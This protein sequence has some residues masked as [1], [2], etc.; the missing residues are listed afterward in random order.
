[1]VQIF[2][3]RV[4]FSVL[5][6]LTK[7]PKHLKRKLSETSKVRTLFSILTWKWNGVGSNLRSADLL[8]SISS[9]SEQAINLNLETM[10]SSGPALKHC[11]LLKCWQCSP[12]YE[13]VRYIQV[14]NGKETSY[15]H[16]RFSSSSSNPTAK[17]NAHKS[18]CSL[19]KLLFPKMV[20]IMLKQWFW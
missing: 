7:E 11:S 15:L 9:F 5:S 4:R 20:E 8:I 13:V 12:Q 1:M 2:S 3:D 6:N 16:Q 17:S 14:N 10:Y 18:V 19:L